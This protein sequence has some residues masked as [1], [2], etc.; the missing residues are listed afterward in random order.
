MLHE[1][2]LPLILMASLVAGGSPGPATL[3]IAGT[4]MASGRAS[5]LALA[6]GITTGSLIW[7]VSA[8]LGL[9][10][11]MLANAWV[12]EVIRYFGASYLMYLAFKSARSALSPKDIAVRSMTGSRSNLY[13][14]GLLL[15]IT[16]P[17]AI[18]FFG[19]LY[20][21]GV[22]AGTSPQNL[23]IVIAC[24]GALSCTM[25]HGYALLFS[26][27]SMTRLY[28]KARRWFEAA[29]AIGFGAASLKILTSRLHS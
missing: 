19:S 20:S 7:S 26:S 2:N 15:H 28:L 4:S 10:A 6:S 14:K 11:L 27:K 25:F 23:A 17:K 29:F 16:N 12:F 22:P 18:L 5:G 3:A 21:L 1:I 24:V 8:A 9:G 13:A